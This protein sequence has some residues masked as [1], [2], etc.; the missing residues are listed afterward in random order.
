MFMLI[1]NLFVANAASLKFSVFLLLIA[2]TI[3]T[4]RT[5]IC[6]FIFLLSLFLS[7]GLCLQILCR[8]G[9]LKWFGYLKQLMESPKRKLDPL[10]DS[11]IKWLE[12]T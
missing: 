2:L 9:C 8:E 12:G 1:L 3:C 5:P 6:L 10:E 4:L 11:L 7:D